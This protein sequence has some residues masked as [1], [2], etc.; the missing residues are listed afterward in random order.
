MQAADLSWN[1]TDRLRD[2]LL[3]RGEISRHKEDPHA[4]EPPPG[5]LSRDAVEEARLFEP[6][7]WKLISALRQGAEQIVETAFSFGMGLTSCA[8]PMG[9]R[10]AASGFRRWSIGCT[11]AR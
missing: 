6:N 2:Y 11:W 7:T 9:T 1:D 4:Y 3:L 8:V 10:R 5:T